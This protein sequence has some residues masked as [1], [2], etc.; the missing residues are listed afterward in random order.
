MSKI[1]LLDKSKKLKPQT[2]ETEEKKMF[3]GFTE[4][5]VTRS[6][7]RATV[8]LTLNQLEEFEYN[9]RL[10]Y[11]EDDMELLM[12]SIKNRGLI[13][14]I[15]V[16]HIKK[17]NRYIIADWHRTKRA[18]EKLYGPKYEVEVM[19]R[20]EFDDY[21]EGAKIYLMEVCFVTSTLKAK[22]S[23]HEE[24]EWVMKYLETKEKM[25]PEGRPYLLSQSRIYNTLG[26]SKS[27]AM[28]LS[29]IIETI[30]RESFS[31]LKS[32]DASYNLLVKLAEVIDKT[33][34][35]PSLQDYAIKAVESWIV[36]SPVELASAT[37]IYSE[38]Q[39]AIPEW[40]QDKNDIIEEITNKRVEAEK[41]EKSKIDTNKDLTN[42]YLR[43]LVNF[44]KKLQNVIIQIDRNKLNLEQLEIYDEQMKKIKSLIDGAEH[45]I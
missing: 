41:E 10:E 15:S 4:D 31:S 2:S 35:N 27:K 6:T 38:V 9:V 18:L 30:P 1:S 12:D 42:K 23:V 36:E 20:R 13:D 14:E 32:Q 24:L 44:S 25:E 7:Q 11:P 37:E 16:V 3:S 26:Y 39:E 22:L 29:K 34:D 5:A 43:D 45:D 40:T 28:K 21:T 19:I 33:K 17:G 8:S